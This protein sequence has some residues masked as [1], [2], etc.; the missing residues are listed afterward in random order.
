MD[1]ASCSELQ[2]AVQLLK[3]FESKGRSLRGRR[4]FDRARLTMTPQQPVQP[5]SI[6]APADD[7]AVAR[8]PTEQLNRAA[9]SPPANAAIAR[10]TERMRPPGYQPYES[11]GERIEEILEGMCLRGG[12]HGAVLADNAG[13]AIADYRCPVETEAIAACSSVL[14]SAMQKAGSLLEQSDAN[15]M[16]M[17]INFVDKV[18][19]RQFDLDGEPCHLLIICPQAVDERSELELSIDRIAGMLASRAA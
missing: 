5:A 14:G 17:D 15:H 11:K 10:A 6:S 2:D 12:F 19:L 13:L 3:S 4:S 7:V 16:T 18:V 1:L 8:Q 9:A